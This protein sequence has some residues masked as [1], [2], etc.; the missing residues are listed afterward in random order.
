MS[1]QLSHF[2]TNTNSNTNNTPQNMLRRPHGRRR[3]R[4]HSSNGMVVTAHE[5]AFDGSFNIVRRLVQQGVDVNKRDSRGQTILHQVAQM[6]DVD[7]TEAQYDGIVEF[8]LQKG[9]TVD[10]LSTDGTT[11]LYMAVVHGKKS[12]VKKLLAN[13]ANPNL[14]P[15]WKHDDDDE[16]G[17]M[18]FRALNGILKYSRNN[19]TYIHQD[20][21]D[22]AEQLIAKG[23]GFTKYGAG[24][25][26]DPQDPQ[27][28]TPLHI[29]ARMGSLRLVKLLIAKGA[30]I[31]KVDKVWGWTALHYASH[32]NHA[33]IA[34]YLIQQGARFNMRNL[35]G[36]TARNWGDNPTTLAV[37]NRILILKKLLAMKIARKKQTIKQQL[38]NQG[39]SRKRR[40]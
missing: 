26:A 40:R 23:A 20:Y 16:G 25:N 37:F 9:A 19:R 39:K 6:V 3:W 8:L 29:A 15:W 17:S 1:N 38:L 2:E 33:H 4:Y 5:A 31:N 12:V 36:K 14:K 11:P 22:I 30:P 24:L 18:L 13:G 35:T 28:L 10:A 27:G 34:R 21:T 7:R 32:Q